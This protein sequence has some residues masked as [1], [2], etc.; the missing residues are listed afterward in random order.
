MPK[1]QKG[2]LSP[3]VII[4]LAIICLFVALT[5][6]VNAQLSKNLIQPIPSPSPSAVSQ[7]KPNEIANDRLSQYFY[8]DVPANSVDPQTEKEIKTTFTSYDP[9]ISFKNNQHLAIVSLEK[10]SPQYIF[11][12][13]QL[14]EANGQPIP[15]D[16]F[17]YILTK[18]SNG[19]KITKNGD[20]FCDVLKTAPEESLKSRRT[21][22]LGCFPAN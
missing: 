13:L 3:P 4:I 17:E 18:N 2:Y 5:L 9:H 19:W 15:A 14:R 12:S 16:G 6:L 10:A 8:W 21:Y 11:A 7:V 1:L 20:N 22:Y